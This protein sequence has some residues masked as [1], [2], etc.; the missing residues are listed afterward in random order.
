MDLTEE[1]Q[2]DVHDLEN[3]LKLYKQIRDLS[4]N[5]KDRFGKNII[6]EKNQSRTATPVFSPDE[7]MTVPAPMQAVRDVLQNLPKKK[8][9]P[10]V[11]VK[12]VISREEMISNLTERVNSSLK[13]SFRDFAKVGKSEK[14]NVIV[15]FLAMLELVKQGVI[16][17]SQENGFDDIQI[18][19]QN[20]GVPRY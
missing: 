14:V 18:E 3:R 11:T 7:S 17:V 19:T 15:S 13:M 16:M 8:S 5:V 6:F 1:E 9:L 20:L 12:K 10:K 4:V 2:G